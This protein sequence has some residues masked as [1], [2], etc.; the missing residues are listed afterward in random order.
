MLLLWTQSATGVLQ[1]WVLDDGPGIPEDRR[2]HLFEPFFTTETRGTGLGLH[3][4]QE[5]CTANGAT[6][7][8]ESSALLGEDIRQRYGAGFVI[9][10]QQRQVAE[11]GPVAAPSR[12]ES[13][14]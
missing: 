1:L 5:L 14:E 6:I 9:T 2:E 12:M 11:A 4:T 8:Y 13:D 7:R 3:L 10:P